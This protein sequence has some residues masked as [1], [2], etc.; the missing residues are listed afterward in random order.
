MIDTEGDPRPDVFAYSTGF[1]IT[2]Y[3]R[4]NSLVSF[5]LARLDTSG[6]DTLYRVDMRAKGELSEEVDPKEDSIGTGIM[7]FYL[8]QTA[9]DG[10]T[11]VPMYYSMYYDEIYPGIDL[12]F[13]SGSGG[14]KMAFVCE[15]ESFPEDNLALEF[16]GQDSIGIDDLSGFLELY[17][18]E[19]KWIELPQAVAYQHSEGEIIPLP[20]APLYDHVEGTMT[21]NFVFE[22]YDSGLPIVLLFGAPPM[23]DPIQTPGVCWSTYFGGDNEDKIWASAIDLAGNYYAAG[24]TYSQAL[25]FPIADGTVITEGYPSVFVSRF[26]QDDHILWSDFYGGSAGDQYASGIAIR[27]GANPKI[28]IAGK[29]EATDLAVLDPTTGEY[30]D[31]SGGGS[32][33]FV[34]RFDEDGVMEWS[35]YFGNGSVFIRNM[36][37]D[38]QGRILIVGDTGGD[39][40]EHQVSLPPGAEQWSFAGG[41][42]DSFIALFTDDDQILWSTFVGGT[43]LDI[44]RSVRTGGQSK[45]VMVGNTTSPSVHPLNPGSPAYYESSSTGSYDAYVI[46]FNAN[47]VEQ[48]GTM[49]GGT[50]AEEIGEQGLA[51]DPSTNDVI[52]V[53]RTTSDDLPLEEGTY[54][55]DDTFTSGYDGFISQFSGSDRSLKWSTYVSGDVDSR[56]IAVVAQSDGRIFIG[57]NTTDELF[58][59]QTFG[60]LYSEDDMLGVGDGVLMSFTSD[61]VYDWGTF[62]GGVEDLDDDIIWS[63]ALKTGEKL[64]AAGTTYAA[65]DLGQF[66]PL[67]DPLTGAWADQILGQP[68]DAFISAFCYAGL[69]VGI[70]ESTSIQ[71]QVL[72]SNIASSLL[73]INPLPPGQYFARIFDASGRVVLEK[74]LKSDGVTALEVGVEALAEGA[75]TFVI[76]GLY[77]GLVVIER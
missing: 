15:P 70:S 30:Y 58:P 46:E 22:E 37:I 75:Y 63:L 56:L 5:C 1:P 26:D 20:W 18:E 25:N 21:V 59:V 39:L 65:S 36:T 33:G 48:W 23:G 24:H 54:W 7:N 34:A 9:P 61:R 74:K 62:F 29:T 3:L 16:E 69:W 52:V 44:A 13:F 2:T 71:P 66:F 11:N 49:F 76:P 12:V 41:G 6:A 47:G 10:V 17:L 53:G 8:P 45:I 14:P 31:D 50:G 42:Q 32:S 19:N 57:G 60:G 77:S 28:Y 73:H 72:L 55:F 40:P 4:E 51:I 67:T 68:E 35:T 38:D 27:D 43:G 64:Y